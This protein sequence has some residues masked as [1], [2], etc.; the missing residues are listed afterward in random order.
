MVSDTPEMELSVIYNKTQTLT[1]KF[2]GS[3]SYGRVLTSDTVKD[4]L[5]AGLREQICRLQ[6]RRGILLQQSSKRISVELTALHLHSIQLPFRD[7]V[8]WVVLS[9]VF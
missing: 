8:G 1:Y 5:V 3:G 9:S 2:S 7:G 6:K 4:V